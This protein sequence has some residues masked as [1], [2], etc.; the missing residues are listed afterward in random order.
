MHA[1]RR[2]IAELEHAIAREERVT[3]KAIL[4]DAIPE[5]AKAAA[6]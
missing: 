4:K 2:W 3:I 6:E 5:F 1:L